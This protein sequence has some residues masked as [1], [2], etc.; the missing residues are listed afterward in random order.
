MDQGGD[1]KISSNA[2]TELTTFNQEQVSIGILN[3]ETDAYTASCDIL[4]L[5]N[6][7]GQNTNFAPCFDDS[8]R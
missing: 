3:A 4:D 8:M 7:M 6:Q 1:Q 5:H 2:E